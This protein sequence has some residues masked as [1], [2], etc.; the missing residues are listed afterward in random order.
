M[1]TTLRVDVDIKPASC[2]RCRFIKWGIPFTENGVY[3]DNPICALFDKPLHDS[4]VWSDVMGTYLGDMHREFARVNE[5]RL[6][7]GK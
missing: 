1:P 7:E 2:A 6:A 5:C 4:D 3:R